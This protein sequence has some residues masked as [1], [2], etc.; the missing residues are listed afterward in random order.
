MRELVGEVTWPRQEGAW[1]EVKEVGID[2]KEIRGRT[3][4]RMTTR[5]SFV[6]RDIIARRDSECDESGILSSFGM[7]TEWADKSCC[8]AVRVLFFLYREDCLQ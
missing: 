4:T 7:T 8:L 2:M 5:K 6:K 1:W 3:R